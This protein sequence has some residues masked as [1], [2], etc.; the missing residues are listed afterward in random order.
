MDK[1]SCSSKE[2]ALG[3]MLQVSCSLDTDSTK[4]TNA[5]SGLTTPRSSTNNNSCDDRNPEWDKFYK[6]VNMTPPEVT[7]GLSYDARL[8][9]ANKLLKLSESDDFK[10]KEFDS[11]TVYQQGLL[12]FVIVKEMHDAFDYLREAARALIPALHTSSP[13]YKQMMSFVL[14]SGDRICPIATMMEQSCPTYIKRNPEWKREC[15]ITIFKA[16]PKM[17]PFIHI[18]TDSSYVCA[19]VACAALLHYCSYNGENDADVFK[20]NVLWYIC[21]EVSGKIIANFTLADLK[22]AYLRKVFVALLKSFGVMGDNLEEIEQISM[23]QNNETLTYLNLE[24]ALKYGRPV[25][26][27]I[28]VFPGFENY[29]RQKFM[30]KISDYYKDNLSNRGEKPED[31]AYHAVLCVGIKPRNGKQPLMLLVQDS[32]S[33]RPFFSIGM[34]L[35]M[36]M[37][38]RCLQFCTAREE[39]KFN[40]NKVYTMTPETRSLV[41]GTPMSVTDSGVPCC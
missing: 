10:D 22:G 8:T 11:L 30:G 7:R 27:A 31:R 21:D 41:C 26:F 33:R 1:I 25:V 14:L 3:K 15:A 12:V 32:S 39:W 4:S 5:D 19:F 40:Q 16:K 28:E 2:K 36:S 6:H 29:N 13:N 23:F 20:L 37:E 24:E 9:T 34:D 35:L 17:K 18:Q 38:L